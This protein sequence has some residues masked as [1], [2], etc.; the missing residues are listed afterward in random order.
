VVTLNKSTE[1]IPKEE[2]V[3][4][5]QI[6]ERESG[7]W[8]NH[9]ISLHGI[10]SIPF[11]HSFIIIFLSSD[12]S[13]LGAIVVIEPVFKVFS[14]FVV[15]PR[16]TAYYAKRKTR[17]QHKWHDASHAIKHNRFI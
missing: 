16:L 14:H 6:G 7:L 10:Y 12:I 15:P 1:I 11:I 13:W 5:E 8:I 17:P 3:K 9:S 2:E 4:G